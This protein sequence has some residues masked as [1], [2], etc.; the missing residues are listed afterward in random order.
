MDY[1]EYLI[2][3]TPV[4]KFKFDREFNDNELEFFKKT[5]KDCYRNH[6]NDTSKNSFILNDVSMKDIKEFAEKALQIYLKE[7]ISPNNIDDIKLAI[8][9]SWL[10]FTKPTEFHHNHYHPN[11]IVSGVFYIN[12]DKNIDEIMF[13]KNE[14][15]VFE[16]ESKNLNDF[17]T[18]E[19]VFKVGK[20]EL[21][22]FPSNTYHTVPP[23]K[24]NE[25][26]ISLAFNSFFK[27]KIGSVKGLTYLEL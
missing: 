8:T 22:L 20:Y 3:P 24:G 4:L 1:K 14:N 15:I 9:Q 17:N 18:K 13:I 6:G 25:T 23:V 21:I 10:N 26:R 7:V 2:F 5:K 19:V 11:S 27:G 12:A 16:L